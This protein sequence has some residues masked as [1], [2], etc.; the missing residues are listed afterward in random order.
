MLYVCLV[1]SAHASYT[2]SYGVDRFGD[3]LVSS[4]A[5]RSNSISLTNRSLLVNTHLSNGVAM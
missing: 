2:L 1:C 5:D 3:C 4:P